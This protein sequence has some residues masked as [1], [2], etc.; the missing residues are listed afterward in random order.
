MANTTRKDQLERLIKEHSNK[1]YDGIAEISDKEFD[2]LIEELRRIDPDSELLKKVGTGY[3]VKGDKV[4]HSIQKI[5]GSSDTKSKLFIGSIDKTREVP[6]ILKGARSIITPK[7]DGISAV[8]YYKKFE[9]D[10]ESN[11]IE[12]LTRGDGTTGISILNKVKNLVPHSLDSNDNL[13]IRGE[14]IITNEDW[15]NLK[16]KSEFKNQRNAVSGIIMSDNSP[17]LDYVTFIP[18]KIIYSTSE[19]R[20]CN[21][22]DELFELSI[23]ARDTIFDYNWGLFWFKYTEFFEFMNYNEVELIRN[24]WYKSYPIDGLIFQTFG[25]GTNVRYEHNTK[26]YDEIAMKFSSEIKQTI[27]TDIE[28]NLTRTG[29]VVPVILIKPI[30]LSGATVSRVSGF[31]IEYL[32]KL[33][34]KTGTV[35]DVTRSNEIIPYIVSVVKTS[36]EEMYVPEYCPS[37]G[38]FLSRKGVNLVCSNSSCTQYSDLLVWVTSLS[39]VH[40]L[41]GKTI[42]SF[43]KTNGLSTVEELYKQLDE[44]KTYRYSD[45]SALSSTE[46]K[47]S[48]MLDRLI[49]LRSG[50]EVVEISEALSALN[51]PLLGY[52]TARD[53]VDRLGIDTIYKIINNQVNIEFYFDINKSVD[54]SILLNRDKLSYLNYLTLVDDNREESNKIKV[55][56]SGKLASGITKKQFYDQYQDIIEESDIKDCDYLISDKEGSTSAKYKKAIELGK[57]ILKSEVFVD[58]LSKGK[59][60]G[61]TSV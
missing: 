16:E 33:G 38:C 9:N 53:V 41:G 6:T 44:I 45:E 15:E 1:Y 8:L 2:S 31:N 30:E 10:S 46:L 34:I 58:N 23:L 28:W 24:D 59:I 35:V 7:L 17:Y 42:R 50:E 5:F 56:I 37:C 25:E 51:I 11:L 43:L 26:I 55:C 22:L 52:K 47:I 14:L 39:P 13:V 18:Y 36:D 21:Y 40:G 32:E 49:N 12:A 48:R 27:V 19:T 3:V 57:T 4:D 60:Q 54:T 20:S 29:K 61:H